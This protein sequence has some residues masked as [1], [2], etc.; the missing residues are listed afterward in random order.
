MFISLC[1][2]SLNVCRRLSSR[3]IIVARDLSQ[4][5][6]SGKWD[7]QA[8]CLVYV[9]RME[10]DESSLRFSCGIFHDSDW[11]LH[12]LYPLSLWA[13]CCRGM[14]CIQRKITPRWHQPLCSFEDV[15]FPQQSR[16]SNIYSSSNIRVLDEVIYLLEFVATSGNVSLLYQRLSVTIHLNSNHIAVGSFTALSVTHEHK[17]EWLGNNN[18]AVGV[19]RGTYMAYLGNMSALGW[20]T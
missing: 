8:L 18:E 9:T 1:Y 13:G 3:R 16:I 11:C 6:L 14:L 12:Y 19:F 10:R 20:K 5:G 15:W 4:I 17:V 2:V 7:F